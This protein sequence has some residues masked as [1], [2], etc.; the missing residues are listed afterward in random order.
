MKSRMILLFLFIGAFQICYASGPFAIKEPSDTAIHTYGGGDLLAKVFNAVS[1][2]I[3]G[4][5]KGTVSKTFNAILRVA[6]TVGGFSSICIAFFREKFEPLVKCF[7]LP[8]VG[9]LSILL[10]P[11]TTVIIQDHL[12]QKVKDAIKPALITVEHVPFFLGKLAS[13]V[14]TVSY[15][16]TEAMEN[17]THPVNG[18]MYNW[19]GHIYAAENI[20]Q[21]RE[22]PDLQSPSGRQFPGILP[23]MRLPRRWDRPVQQGGSGE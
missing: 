12:V 2:L 10:V 14:S 19:T 7:F 20:F 9:I 4:N 11:R 8:A 23:G 21:A 18:P 6:L 16:F 13:L 15:N 3:Y 22:M 1:M 17:V 5:D